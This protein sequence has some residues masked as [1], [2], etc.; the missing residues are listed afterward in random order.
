MKLIMGLL[1]CLGFAALVCGAEEQKPELLVNPAQNK[2]LMKKAWAATVTMDYADKSLEEV[3][4]DLAKQSGVKITVD[5]KTLGAR[6]DGGNSS[7]SG[8]GMYGCEAAARNFLDA[9]TVAKLQGLRYEYKTS[10]RHIEKLKAE[11]PLPL[12]LA[13]DYLSS[14]LSLSASYRKDHIYVSSRLGLVKE[15]AVEKSYTLTHDW[16][17]VYEVNYNGEDMKFRL[18]VEDSVANQLSHGCYDNVLKIFMHHEG[19][20]PSGAAE[21]LRGL[22]LGMDVKHDK[23][24]HTVTVTALPHMLTGLQYHITRMDRPSPEVLKA[25]AE[26]FR[27][28]RIRYFSETAWSKLPQAEQEKLTKAVTELDANEYATRQA[29]EKLLSDSGGASLA[30]LMKNGNGHVSPE[31]KDRLKRIRPAAYLNAELALLRPLIDGYFKAGREGDLKSMRE[32]FWDRARNDSFEKAKKAHDEQLAAAKGNAETWKNFLK[33]NQFPEGTQPGNAGYEATVIPNL[34]VEDLRVEQILISGPRAKVTYSAKVGKG[35]PQAEFVEQLKQSGIDRP[36]STFFIEFK[37]AEWRVSEEGVINDEAAVVWN[38]DP[39][40]K[41]AA[42]T[43]KGETSVDVGEDGGMIA[44]AS[45]SAFA[46]AISFGY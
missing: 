12:A 42:G 9:A 17:D 4:A 29:A 31:V 41:L 40:D 2:E 8:G 15:L 46:Y 26:S 38:R 19:P 34:K 11:S 32:K 36:I 25:E 30:A 14:S 27:E 5:T 24:R 6:D 20:D 10:G 23:A 44:S 13:I 39:K 43:S 37:N 28:N 45:A 18:S 7:G 3:F 33:N 1:I 22:G 16:G 35:H 21:R